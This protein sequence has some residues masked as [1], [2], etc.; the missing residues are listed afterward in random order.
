MKFEI[1]NRLT[2]EVIFT[3]E[4]E[5]KEDAPRSIKL[6]LAV[7]VA[8]EAKANLRSADLR[9]ANLESA[10]LRSANL[11]SANLESANLESANLESAN[12]RYMA[13]GNNKQLKTLQLGLYLVAISEFSI[14]IGCC[15]FSHDEWANF[16]DYEIRN[17]DGKEAVT[18]WAQWKETIL[19]VANEFKKKE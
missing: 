16:N 4:I 5:C 19:K 14:A 6:G 10:N 11:R 18:W 1:K 3:A 7:K 17:L 13:S 9:Y 2:A 8:I 15:Q 12:L